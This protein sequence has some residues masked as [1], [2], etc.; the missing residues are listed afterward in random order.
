MIYLI[1]LALDDANNLFF[2]YVDDYFRN[3][4]AKGHFV[5][6]LKYY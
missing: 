3:R 6:L 4:W 2:D 1:F 5:K